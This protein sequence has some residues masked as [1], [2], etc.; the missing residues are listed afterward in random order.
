[1]VRLQPDLLA[2]LD[3]FAEDQSRPEAI[4]ALLRD[5]LIRLGC[6]DSSSK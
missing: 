6:L 2:A 4:R 5:N 3:K 1:M